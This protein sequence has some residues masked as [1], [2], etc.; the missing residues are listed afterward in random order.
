M[1]YLASCSDIYLMIEYPG[2]ENVLMYLAATN[3]LKS[4]LKM[5]II[6]N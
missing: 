1:S 6:I 3:K 5:G 2:V 4:K